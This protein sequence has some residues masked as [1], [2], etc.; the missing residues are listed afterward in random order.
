M[1]VSAKNVDRPA[2]QQM[3]SEVDRFER[4]L[5]RERSR[6]A[7]DYGDASTMDKWFAAR[8]VSVWSLNE[9]YT[10]GDDPSSFLVR[11]ITDVFSA[12][13]L[14]DLSHKVKAGHRTRALKGLHGGPTP[15]GYIRA[16]DK[17]PME[18]DES[19]AET[20]RQI[21]ERYNSGTVS[22][23]DLARGL[24]FS[25]TPSPTGGPWKK[26]SI[27]T[28]LGNATY[29]GS[30]RHHGRVVAPGLH[31]GVID[32]HTFD[33][34]Q[35]MAHR[36][37]NRLDMHRG[38]ER[39][40]MLSG[41][42]V[43]VECRSTLNANTSNGYRYYRCTLGDKGLATRCEHRGHK[44]EPVEDQI[45]Q[46]FLAWEAPDDWAERVGEV[47]STPQHNEA[48]RRSLEARIARAEEAWL[49]GYVE[50]TKARAQIDTARA[51]LTTLDTDILMITG[52]DF[53]TAAGLW[54]HMTA[55]ERRD[56]V[57]LFFDEIEVDLGTGEVIQFT[58]H[59]EVAPHFV[60]VAESD[61]P[62]GLCAWWAGWD[63]NPRATG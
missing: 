48:R 30:V 16:G 60:A 17:Q 4:V 37:R 58:V 56:T 50:S 24:N 36:R 46:M 19:E 8:G 57:R 38:P 13:Y 11:G 49:E 12:H 53:R 39:A 25:E 3:V 28:I 14:V 33:L 22:Y 21:F 34:A 20:I 55:E 43:H 27:R 31:D 9:P 62:I 63:S 6:Y 52:E 23:A 5:V 47:L 7:R 15:Y 2:F 51:E 40:Y 45:S 18:V 10:N 29:T 26:E 35:R 44:A 59:P 54:P 32:Q 61:G 42:G 1:G 41:T